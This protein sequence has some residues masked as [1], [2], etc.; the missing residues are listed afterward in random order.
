MLINTLQ[1]THST[2]ELYKMID[3]E[4]HKFEEEYQKAKELRL[5]VDFELNSKLLHEKNQMEIG[6]IK[7]K[8]VISKKGSEVDLKK[9][10][11]PKDDNSLF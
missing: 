4:L 10:I 3:D 6:N 2:S 11:K 8:K 5:L 1:T 9:R 7:Y